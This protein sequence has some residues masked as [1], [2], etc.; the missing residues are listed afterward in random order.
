M[1]EVA[2]PEITFP[3]GAADLGSRAVL[4]TALLLGARIASR[5]ALLV[6]VLVMANH[7]G[8]A[9]YGRYSSLVT[10]SGI[11]SILT[12]FGLNILYTREAA[13]NPAALPRF[14]AT[15]AAGKLPLL[16]LGFIAL[17]LA[18][19]KAGLGS[20]VVPG[21]ALM[22]AS[23]Y[24]N[25]LRNTFYA[26]GR[27]EFEAVAVLA[28]TVIQGGGILY[29]VTHGGDVA[30]FLLV[31]AASYTFTCVYTLVVVPVFR[32]AEG[33]PA[34][35][36][37][38]FV[39]WLVLALPIAA[40]SLLTNLYFKADVPLLLHFRPAAE[41]G[42]YTLA[43]KPFEALQFIPLA[44]Q[45]VVYPVLSVRFVQA[46]DR[47]N[48]AYHEFFR[49]LVLLGLPLTAGTFVL[50]HPIGRFFH[51]FPQSHVSLRI[52][53]L[54]IVFLFVNSA[55]TAMFYSVNRQHLFAW[56]T[57]IAVVVNVGLNLAFIPRWGYLATSAN[58]V[59]TEAAFSVVAWWFLRARQPLPWLR[60][61]W[62]MLPATLLL[63]GVAYWFS[64]HSL[65]IAAPLAGVAY[66]VGLWIFR[67]VSPEELD[68]FLRG[69]RLRR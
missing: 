42:W 45:S 53:A 5:L 15:M 33:R 14:L 39:K 28:E 32:L 40:G 68:L 10:Y 1:S 36:P 55:F 50:A 49:I 65:L 17:A 34:L 2:P 67:A 24:V 69:L 52:L 3:K 11:L 48:R 47:L 60:L 51:L 56:T 44:L 12:D 58:T 54:A 66:L 59:I 8:A 31:Y 30:F 63:A 22:A 41:V 16:P 29:G 35:D 64:D 26:V 57:G 6:L 25:L 18:A 27:L 7:L 62:R 43:Y 61:T 20:L 9:G 4:N 38:L 21:I 13:R 23:T 19:T 37:A 46:Q